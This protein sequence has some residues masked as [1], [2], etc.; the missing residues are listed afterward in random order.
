M[1]KQLRGGSA[2]SSN[3]EKHILQQ[4][5]F[6]RSKDLKNYSFV[7]AGVFIPIFAWK[8]TKNCSHII[9]NTSIP[10]RSLH[11]GNDQMFKLDVEP[12]SIPE[13]DIELFYRLIARLLFTS[14]ITRP[15][16]QACVT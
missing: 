3:G 15:E 5:L 12:P 4:R 11:S 8:L 14:K 16:V 10:G 13:K 7:D 6:Y 1:S 9:S 2:T